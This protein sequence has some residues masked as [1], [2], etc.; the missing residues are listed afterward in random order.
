MIALVTGEIGEADVWYKDFGR[1][2]KSGAYADLGEEGRWG[3]QILGDHTKVEYV[4]GSMGGERGRIYGIQ[5]S[6]TK[7]N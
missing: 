6:H 7:V 2:W 3:V 4:K 1:P 5:R